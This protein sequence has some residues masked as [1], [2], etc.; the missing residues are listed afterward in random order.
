MILKIGFTIYTWTMRLLL[1]EAC[2]DLD[3]WC[4]Y[5][6]KIFDIRCTVYTFVLKNIFWYYFVALWLCG[7]IVMD[8]FRCCLS[9]NKKDSIFGTLTWVSPWWTIEVCYQLSYRASATSWAKGPTYSVFYRTK[10]CTNLNGSKYVT[11][12]PVWDMIHHIWLSG[13]ILI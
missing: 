10:K 6:L 7:K 13:M 4:I 8:W 5:F 12:W 2:D 11:W 1:W 9:C 3:G